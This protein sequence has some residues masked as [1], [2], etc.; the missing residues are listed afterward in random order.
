MSQ[1]TARRTK[2]AR[3]DRFC[4]LLARVWV[5][6]AWSWF[7]RSGDAYGGPTRKPAPRYAVRLQLDLANVLCFLALLTRRDVELDLLTFVERLVSVA[8][9]RG[10]VDEHVVGAFARNEAETLFGVEKL[11]STCSQRTLVSKRGPPTISDESACG[12]L[13]AFR[14]ITVRLSLESSVEVSRRPNCLA[15]L[16]SRGRARP[17]A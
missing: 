15:I 14:W 2:S 11:D 12:T 7:N 9:N 17:F 13:S 16:T 6:R 5:G 10:E 4:K 3:V 8:L 1:P